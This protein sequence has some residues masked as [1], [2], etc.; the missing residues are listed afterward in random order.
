[1]ENLVMCM[2]MALT[3]MHV[4]P[5]RVQML[6]HFSSLSFERK[7][8]EELESRLKQMAEQHK[9]ELEKVRSM[10]ISSETLECQVQQLMVQ[11][12]LSTSIVFL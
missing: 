7:R 2:Y 10:A 4:I 11:T 3:S 1:M 9:V 12:H 6:V 5:W 8:V